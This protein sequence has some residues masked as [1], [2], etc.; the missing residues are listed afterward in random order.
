VLTVLVTTRN[1]QTTLPRVLKAYGG[2]EFPEG[3]WALIIVDNGSTDET[4][5]ILDAFVGRLPL[6]V[7]HEARRGQ[8]FAR[9]AALDAVHGDL[10]VFSDD[11]AIPE[12]RWLAE[13]RRAA[14][15][16]PDFSIF[17]GT[18]L[19]RWESPPEPW[20]LRS[21]P[22]GAGFALTDPEWGEGPIRPSWVFSPN[23]AIRSEVFAAGHRF[24]EK[25]GPQEGSYPMG[26]ETELTQRLYRTGLRA[27]HVKTAVVE[28]VIR[29]Y[30]LTPGWLLSRAVRFGR[31]QYRLSMLHRP[32]SRNILG[33]VAGPI[34]GIVSHGVRLALARFGRDSEATFHWQW[35]LRCSIGNALEAVAIERA[36]RRSNASFEQTVASEVPRP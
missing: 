2:L 14:D 27:W 33:A 20:I 3:G 29:P 26:S 32:P 8:N 23:M 28:H 13:L 11:D 17:G 22:L 1:G 12:H 6:T 30:Q 16:H 21:V 10:V 4:R 15:A 36:R 35:N 31:G 18:I 7:L 34:R 25:F 24:D 19:P 5:R 9:N